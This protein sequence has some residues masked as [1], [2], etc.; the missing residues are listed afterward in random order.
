M[1]IPCLFR[2]QYLLNFMRR[3][4]TNSK[5]MAG[6]AMVGLLILLGIGG[7][8]TRQKGIIPEKELIKTLADL[9]TARAWQRVSG[10][11]IPRMS[12]DSVSLAVLKNNGITPEELDSTLSWY[13]RNVDD[14]QIL[15]AKVEREL[16]RRL[17]EVSKSQPLEITSEGVKDLWNFPRFSRI[18]SEDLMPGLSFNIDNPD[19]EPGEI[20][21]WKL[22][23]VSGNNLEIVLGGEYDGGQ[24]FYNN[25]TIYARN[26]T[27]VKL[28][29]DSTRR[30]LRLYGT[31]E[32]RGNSSETVLIDSLALLILPKDDAQYFRNFHQ[33]KYSILPKR[34]K[35]ETKEIPDSTSHK[36]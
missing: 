9:E 15:Y 33:K 4:L 17:N 34:K 35:N 29:T 11:G 16:D 30:L 21:E 5:R 27:S 25:S 10:P 14:Y 3:G 32:P 22:R 8:C 31:I 2:P 28:Y 1:K 18:T 24:Y 19:I 23:P 20:I 26:T 12:G 7:A 6:P 36:D 13:G